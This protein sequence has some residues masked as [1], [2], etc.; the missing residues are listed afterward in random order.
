M[1]GWE[2]RQGDVLDRLRELP[3]ES[4]QCCITSPPYYGL[5]DYGVEGQIGLEGT[6]R[7]F[8]EK[9]VGVFAEVRRVLRADG[10]L[11]LNLGD[12]YASGGNRWPK[13]S[14][15][16]GGRVMH[17][18]GSTGCKPK[19]LLGVPWM[20]AFALRA[21]G[22]YLRR[23]IIWSKPN[24][25]PES[26][27][28]RP[29]S[30][31]EYIFLLSKSPSYHYDAQAIRERDSGRGSGNGFDQRLDHRLTQNGV[32]KVE[33][34]LPGA[35]RNK[36]SVWEIATQP[37]PEAHFATFPERLVE[38]MVLAG[39]SPKACGECGAPWRRLVEREV[40][41]SRRARK[42]PLVPRVSAES[43]RNGHGSATFGHYLTT[44]TVGW[45]PTCEHEDDSGSCLV[46]DPFAGS[47]TTLKVAVERGQR[48]LGIE[49][50]PEYVTLAERR[51]EGVT[52]PL[53]TI[54]IVGDR[55]ADPPS[56]G[57][58]A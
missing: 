56:D 19:D 30:A 5:R 45:E 10:T 33:P 54:E 1:S 6:P 24:P 55:D 40:D 27:S 53:F 51:L 28:D 42:K 15:N 13:Q 22:W 16:A 2:V 32:G 17:A 7:E 47:G 12:S 26:V 31:H 58:R 21:D 41:E 14:R 49:L 52:E 3:D 9:M 35:G 48:A 18:K 39:T 34:W 8:V 57:R 25:M 11:W 50:N 23:D 43:G 20:V 38:P 44:R 46:L 36:R 4:V 37:Y 29:T